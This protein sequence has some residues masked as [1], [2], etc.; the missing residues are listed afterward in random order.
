MKSDVYTVHL[1]E[2]QIWFPHTI[3][4]RSL[5]RALLL[6]IIKFVKLNKMQLNE[7]KPILKVIWIRN[8]FE[9]DQVERLTEMKSPTEFLKYVSCL[10]NKNAYNPVTKVY[11][12]SYCIF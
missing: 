1:T 8:S 12:D 3:L 2:V 9:I 6:N 5:R 7:M 10:R 11:R 4:Y